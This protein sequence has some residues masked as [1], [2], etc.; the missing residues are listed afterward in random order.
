VI[1]RYDPSPAEGLLVLGD[2]PADLAR[3]RLLFDLE[4]AAGRPLRLVFPAKGEVPPHTTLDGVDAEW[5]VHERRSDVPPERAWLLDLAAAD[6]PGTVPEALREATVLLASARRSAAHD[7]EWAF[8]ALGGTL[9]TVRRDSRL[10]AYR[11]ECRLALGPALRA[12][13]LFGWRLAL[14]RFDSAE[15]L[16]EIVAARWRDKFPGRV[17]LAANSTYAPDRVVYAF[18]SRGPLDPRAILLTALPSNSPQARLEPDGLG[19][20]G[21]LSTEAFDELLLRL[22]FR[23]TGEESRRR[24]TGN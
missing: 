24:P 15:S 4:A 14:V 8:R 9:Q 7:L 1:A 10:A 21:S 12:R 5:T 23:R 17:V 19:G 16:E 18:R 20:R 11:E 22:R 13:P 3:G 6:G 2:E